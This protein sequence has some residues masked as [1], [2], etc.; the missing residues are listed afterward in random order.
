MY[1]QISIYNDEN[2]K[3]HKVVNYRDNC[4]DFIILEK[5]KNVIIQN[6]LFRLIYL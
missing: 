3:C 6:V 2:E 5:N 4:D 1:E